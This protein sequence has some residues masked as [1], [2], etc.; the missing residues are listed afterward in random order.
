MPEGLEKRDMLAA[1]VFTDLAND[2]PGSTAYIT[3]TGYQPGE[4]IEF[5]V[6]HN[7][8][9]SNTGSGHAP[10]VV[11]DSGGGDLDGIVNG[12]VT[13][14]WYVNPD[15]SSGSSFDLFAKGLS[16]GLLASTTFADASVQTDYH[17]W[18]NLH[19]LVKSLILT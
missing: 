3:A 15:D 5:Q 4:Q 9:T 14:T 19:N 1:A 10:W 11:T 17:G 13:T 7:D 12:N 16:S 18:E 2:S 6:L 8:G